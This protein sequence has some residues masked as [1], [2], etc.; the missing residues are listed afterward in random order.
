MPRLDGCLP[1]ACAC[2]L[3]YVAAQCL[4]A[5]AF[6]FSALFAV[7]AVAL[8]WSGYRGAA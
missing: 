7:I 1:Y 2:G 4:V 8:A 3:V 6:I 5:G